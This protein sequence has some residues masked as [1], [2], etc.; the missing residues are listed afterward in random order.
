ME[1]ARS[2]REDFLHQLAFHNVDTYTSSFKQLLMM[3]LVCAFYNKS[4][5]ALDRGAD[6]GLVA[7]LPVRESIGR[8]KYVPEDEVSDAFEKIIND[9][10]SQLEGCMKGEDD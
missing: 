5:E 8:F 1:A 10:D 6:I 2:I 4:L 9:L 3:R 7:L